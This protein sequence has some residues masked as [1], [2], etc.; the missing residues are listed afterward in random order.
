[1]TVLLN[2]SIGRYFH[3]PLHYHSSVRSEH[4]R[5]TVDH[6]IQ[7]IFRYLWR[8]DRSLTNDHAE[9]PK[10]TASSLM[11]SAARRAPLLRDSILLTGNLVSDTEDGREAAVKAGGEGAFS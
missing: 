7:S 4:S 8:I 6:A 10:N 5:I 9:I 11:E 3:G 2:L 1:M